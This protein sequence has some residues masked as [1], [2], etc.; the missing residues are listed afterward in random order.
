MAAP[1]KESDTVEF[2]NESQV[3][4]GENA[5]KK[6][7]PTYGTVGETIHTFF[8]DKVYEDEQLPD[9]ITVEW[10][11]KRYTAYF[12]PRYQENGA[13]VPAYHFHTKTPVH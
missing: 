4:S 8:P 5:V 3:V 11:G 2:E 1:R 10:Q 7:Y 6:S 12:E 9:E 13:R